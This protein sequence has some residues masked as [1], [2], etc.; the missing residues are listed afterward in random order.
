MG[1]FLLR[2]FIQSIIILLIVTF[3]GFLL[4]HLIPGD[5]VK[6]MLGFEATQEEIDTLRAELRL[7]RPML[8]QY[9]HWLANLLRG[10]LGTSLM[11]GED[12]TALVM[13]RLPVT[14]YVGSV[15]LLLASCIGIPGGVICAV[16]RGKFLDSFISVIANV[17]ISI[18]IFWLGILGIYLFSLKLGWLPIQGYT[19][20]FEDFWLSIR[21]VMMPAIC[22]AVIPLSSITR[23]TRSAMLEVAAQDYIRTAW[24]KGLRERVIIIRHTLKNGLIPVVTLLGMH[25]RYLVGGSVLV[26]T[27]F[28]I[29][30][31]GR[32]IVRSVFDKDFVIVQACVIVIALVVVLSNLAVD[33]SYG[34]IDPRIRHE[35]V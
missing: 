2:R 24:A 32:L 31:M 18:P 27:V 15:A 25:L 33:I 3:L 5:P 10:N 35:K 20:P 34:Y 16:R 11:Y 12:V 9:G 23:Q 6:T 4:I 8:V 1:A 22:L 14:L 28:N 30:G 7:D 17:G 21:K 26:E 13:R 29:P 19:S